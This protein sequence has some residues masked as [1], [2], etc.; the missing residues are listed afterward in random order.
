LNSE[1][2]R[3]ELLLVKE[4]DKHN[5]VYV[6]AKGTYTKVCEKVCEKATEVLTPEEMKKLLLAANEL[7]TEEFETMR[8]D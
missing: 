3:T 2:V 5:A 7:N 6:A 4:V 1:E 8:V